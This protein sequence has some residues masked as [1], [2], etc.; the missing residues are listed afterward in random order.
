LQRPIGFAEFVKKN[1][2]HSV[3]LITP[4]SG[5][6]VKVGVAEDP[7]DRLGNLQTANFLP[8][9]IHRFWW[10]P[11]KQVTLRVESAFK[12]HFQPQNIR[13]E[14]FDLPLETAEAFVE[15]SIRSLGTWGVRQSDIVG[16]MDQWARKKYGLPP[17]AP[18]PLR[19]WQ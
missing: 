8:L 6:P 4:D 12:E 5:N 13:G 14:W 10:M 19:G 2:F 11:G 1:G 7:A 16:L 3:Y 9:R 18:S 15:E 17:E